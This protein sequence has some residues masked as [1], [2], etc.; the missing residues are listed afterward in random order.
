INI[1]AQTIAS[2]ARGNSEDLEELERLSELAALYKT[3]CWLGALIGG[4][5]GKIIE[6]LKFFGL[7]FGILREAK[8]SSIDIIETYKDSAKKALDGLPNGPDREQLK[9]IVFE[10]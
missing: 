9:L 3:S 8:G 1:L 6:A 7:N 4:A 10:N 5:N 2:F